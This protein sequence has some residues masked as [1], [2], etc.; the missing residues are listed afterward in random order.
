MCEKRPKYRSF[1]AQGVY[2]GR[3]K[4]K[5]RLKQNEQ[6]GSSISLLPPDTLQQTL[7]SKLR[8]MPPNAGCN[9]TAALIGIRATRDK[10]VHA[11]RSNPL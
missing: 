8:L 2:N 7:W 11:R 1:Y 9:A 5:L 10:V 6:S 3:H 4:D